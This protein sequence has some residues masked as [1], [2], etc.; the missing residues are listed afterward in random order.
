MGDADFRLVLEDALA[1][2]LV[3]MC[4]DGFWDAGMT[5]QMYRDPQPGHVNNGWCYRYAET[6]CLIAAERGARVSA[7]WIENLWSRWQFVRHCVV[8]RGCV[9]YDAECLDGAKNIDD[10]PYL[11]QMSGIRVG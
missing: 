3:Q 9:F 2:I 6:A 10:L 5:H 8:V 11:Q 7:V 1:N 4:Q